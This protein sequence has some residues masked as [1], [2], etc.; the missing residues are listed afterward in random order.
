MKSNTSL[1]Y[2]FANFSIASDWFFKWDFIKIYKIFVVVKHYIDRLNFVIKLKVGFY[3]LN[4]AL[5]GRF[6]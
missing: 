4:Y 6:S 2:Y 5:T 1:L 3:D